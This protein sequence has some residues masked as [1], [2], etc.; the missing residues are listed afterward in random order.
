MVSHG[1]RAH[2]ST[3]QSVAVKG[4]T[5]RIR[6]IVTSGLALGV[7]STLA[8]ATSATAFA[9]LTSEQPTA[10]KHPV[11]ALSVSPAKPAVG[12]K[13][14]ANAS[15]SRLPK[16]DGLRRATVRFGDGS[17]V[18]VHSLKALVRHAYAKSGTY[19]VV[20][21]IVDKHGVKVT[22]S[23]RVT[24]HAVHTTPPASNGLP[25]KIPAGLPST[26]PISSLGLSPT[27]LSSVAARLGIP[28]GTLT[29]LPVGFLGLLPK[30]DLT[31]AGLPSL[32]GLS[33][34]PVVGDL[35]SLLSGS[36]GGLPFSLPTNGDLTGSQLIGS[37]PATIL[38]SLQ[39]T[40]LSTLFG[41]PTSVL[42]GLPLSI[43]SLLPGN[44]VQYVTPGAPALPLAIP[45]GL[46]P[47]SLISSLGLSSTALSSVSSLIGIPA[48]TLP[49]L[50]VGFLSLLPTGD[51]TGAGLPSLPG[52][53]GLPVV[54]D[55]VSL[56][57]GSL[58]GLPFSL[59]T[60]LGLTGS[61]LI[62]TVPS[63]VLSSLQLTSLSTLFGVPTS[64]LSG[65]PLSILSLLPGNLV[66]F[67][68]GSTPPPSSGLPITIPAGLSPSSLIS[69]LGL[70]STALSSL[71]SLLA[72]PTSTLSGLPVGFLGLLPTGDLTGAGLPSLPGLASI[73]LVG[74]LVGMLLAGL[75][76]SIPS[77]ILPTT[78]ISALPSGV[79]SVLQLSTLSTYFGVP[80]S[81][82]NSLPVNV[83]TLLPAGLLSGL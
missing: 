81:V 37:V 40:S 16:G 53:A 74:N 32:P 12:A 13:I 64:V 3:T 14:V 11:A 75:P 6:P 19:T 5:V 56:L 42:S 38:S 68:S 83:L 63:T 26:T 49:S 52:L 33:G 78:L 72:I 28:A 17:A 57:S 27:A 1:E 43:L 24:V 70:S 67:V 60:N 47:T 2:A 9:A 54:G 44:L 65:L 4:I 82:L 51:L 34:L 25:V 35:V 18:T 80:T 39:L 30:G 10:P 23:K 55:L 22:K 76:I 79:L 36:L 58:G 71:S 8:V 46:S 62:G 45:A 66:Q 61:Q 15:H 41:V 7:A 59:P 31:G 20:L 73:P 77:G 69:S 21:T 48:G 50:P 29:G